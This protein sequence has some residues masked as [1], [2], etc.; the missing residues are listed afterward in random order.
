MAA[1]RLTIAAMLV[2][3]AGNFSAVAKEYL[4]K[5]SRNDGKFTYVVEGTTFNFFTKEGTSE[6][7]AVGGP[8]YSRYSVPGAMPGPCHA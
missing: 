5:A 1:W 8:W 7:G 4:E 2:V 3:W 6:S